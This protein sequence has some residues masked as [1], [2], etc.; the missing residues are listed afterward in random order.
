MIFK[1]EEN[2]LN[3]KILQTKRFK[4]I[5][6]QNTYQKVQLYKKDQQHRT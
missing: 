6:M 2:H 5:K 4:L 3:R 1:K